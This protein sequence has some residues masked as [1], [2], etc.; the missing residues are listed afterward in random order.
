MTTHSGVVWNFTRC[1]TL[2]PRASQVHYNTYCISSR[3]YSFYARLCHCPYFSVLNRTLSVSCSTVWGV[4]DGLQFLGIQGYNPV[5]ECDICS[6]SSQ[7]NFL[8]SSFTG[9]SNARFDGMVETS[10]TFSTCVVYNI[11]SLGLSA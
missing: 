6:V 7:L 2:Q 10:M 3:L 4:Q 8:V 11:W 9:A 1:R 5:S